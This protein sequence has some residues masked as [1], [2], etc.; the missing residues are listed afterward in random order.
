MKPFVIFALLASLLALPATASALT[1]RRLFPHK[2]RRTQFLA[3]R[4]RLHWTVAA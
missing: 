4:A 1:N 2:G 3:S